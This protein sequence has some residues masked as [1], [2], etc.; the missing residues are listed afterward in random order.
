MAGQHAFQS[1]NGLPIT[2]AVNE[3]VTMNNDGSDDGMN[4]IGAI[5]N[6]SGTNTFNGPISVR[7]ASSSKIALA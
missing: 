3:T 4:P 5:E 7:A 6:I 2:Y 1:L